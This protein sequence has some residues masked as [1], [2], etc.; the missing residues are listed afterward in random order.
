MIV[1]LDK[2][3]NL[4]FDLAAISKFEE[5][6]GKNFFQAGTFDSLKTKEWISLIWAGLLYDDPTL[7]QEQVGHLVD[8]PTM[9]TIIGMIGKGGNEDKSPL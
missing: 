3:R 9:T 6:T 2:E 4:R 1:K 7:T 8:L 5:E